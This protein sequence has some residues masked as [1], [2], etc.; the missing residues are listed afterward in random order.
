[1]SLAA[2]PESAP[3]VRRRSSRR[4]NTPKAEP[5]TKIGL[6]ITADAARRLAVHAAMEGRDRSE[7][8]EQL[9]SEYLKTYRVQR[10]GPDLTDAAN[11]DGNGLVNES[12][13]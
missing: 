9:I 8:V 5:K 10:V 7:I 1:M 12:A 11:L 4:S 3:K 6:C 2:T 13:A